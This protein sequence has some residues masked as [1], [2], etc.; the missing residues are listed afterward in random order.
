M[1]KG[2][3]FL[4]AALSASAFAGEA[5]MENLLFSG[6]WEHAKEYSRASA[7]AVTV[8]F[9]T[10]GTELLFDLEGEARWLLTSDGKPVDTFVTDRR[11]VHKFKALDADFHKYRLIK[12]TESNPG[13]VRLYGI[14]SN[15]EFKARPKASNRRIEFIGDSFTVGYGNEGSVS[16]DPSLF[17][18]KTNASK[19]Y[20]FLLAESFKA[21]FQVNAVSGRG[22]VRNYDNIV[23]AWPLSRLY[24]YTLPG[25]AA[26]G[27]SPLWNFDEFHPQVIVVFVGI[28][29]FQG[30]PP[31]CKKDKFKAAYVSLLDKLRKVHPGCKFLLLST[32]TWPNDDMAPA[33]KE[34][35]DSEKAR[36]KDDLEYKHVLT[37]NT[38]LVGHPN[39]HSH[40]ALASELR[41]IIGRLGRWLSR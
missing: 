3:F 13:E 34:I 10:A 8:T 39:L 16:D 23:P 38:A 27:A 30:N 6:R 7:P 33:I 17:F 35:F 21:D 20:A 28:N 40:E 32:K 9:E 11:T 4:L 15:G 37:E 31:Y 12:L 25:M 2:V 26:E 18:E 5:S 19:S 1:N 29:D 14:S 41:P 22:M 36:G 24:D